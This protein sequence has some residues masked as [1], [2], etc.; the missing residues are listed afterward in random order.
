MELIFLSHI[1]QATQGAVVGIFKHP[2]SKGDVE[3]V[4]ENDEHT[5]TTITVGTFLGLQT[6]SYPKSKFQPILF[7]DGKR[8]SEMM[9]NPQTFKEWYDY[10]NN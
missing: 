9:E 7:P 6:C 10:I 4:I 2:M 3:M 8:L 5:F 1:L